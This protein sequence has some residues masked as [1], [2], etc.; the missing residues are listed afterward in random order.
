MKDNGHRCVINP[1]GLRCSTSF[2]GLSER[3][4]PVVYKLY[5]KHVSG[6]H[7]KLRLEVALEALMSEVADLLASV[8]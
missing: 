3:I 1:L 7:S 4:F 5:T 8:A 6:Y 2:G